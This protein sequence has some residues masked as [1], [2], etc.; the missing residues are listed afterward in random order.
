[1]SMTQMEEDVLNVFADLRKQEE[2]H[3][4]KI[5]KRLKKIQD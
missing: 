1:M 3:A 2:G 4:A 5:R